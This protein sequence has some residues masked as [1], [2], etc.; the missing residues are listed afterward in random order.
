MA[1]GMT[2]G[3]LKDVPAFHPDVLERP[4]LP[5]Y[6]YDVNGDL[7]T[8][9]HDAQKRIPIKMSDV[10]EDLRNAFLAAEDNNFFNHAGFDAK[11]FL[12]AVYNNLVSAT[13]EGGS[14]LTQQIVKQVFVGTERKM[15]RKIKELY[16]A[17]DME[18]RYTKDEIFEF[19]IN[20]VT[21]YGNSAYGV[22]A[23][24][25]TY[26][27]KSVSELT[28]SESALLAGIPNWPS[29]YAPNSD[30]IG[31]DS[32]AVKRRNDV[33]ARMLRF[34]Y[35]TQEEFDQAKTEEVNLKLSINT[36]WPFPHFVDA[37]VH[38]HAIDALMSTGRYETRD[39]AAQA[40]R[41]DG[42]NIY[43]TLDPRIQTIVQDVMS[44]DKYYPKDT[45]EYPEGHSRAGRRYPQSAAVVMNPKTGYVYGMV[46]GREFNSVNRLNR[47]N[48]RFQPGSSIKPILDYG[49]AFELG[50]L[51]PASTIDDAPTVWPSVGAKDYTPENFGRNFKG[52]VTVRDALV[53]SDNIPAIKTYE[54]ILQNAGAKAGIEFAQKAGITN[55]GERNRNNPTAYAQLG[56]AI[57]S[58]EVT[59]LEMA[60]AYSAFANKGISTS[61]IFVTK[62]VDRDNL[63]I[64]SA[65]MGTQTVVFSEQ[66]AWQ[67]TD[68]LRDVVLRGTL[69]G[70]NLRNY[71]VAGKTGTT[72]DN[73]DRWRVGYTSDYVFSLWMGNDNKQATVD[74]KVVFIPGT[75]S[76]SGFSQAFGEIV[77]GTIG[78]NDVP[79]PSRPSGLVQVT[80]C[81][82]SGK[83][84]G[85]Y[86]TDTVTD[87]FT[88][89]TVPTETCDLHVRVPICTV[90]GLLATENCPD[91]LV[92]YKVFLNRPEVEPTDDRWSGAVGRLPRD[93]HLRPPTEYCTLHGVAYN[94]Q[95]S[96]GSLF[97]DWTQQDGSDFIGFNVY[98]TAFGKTEKLN[99][100][101]LNIFTRSFV[102]P[103]QVPGIPYEYR[104]VL[105][106]SQ[107][108]ETQRH[109]PIARTRTID[110]FILS[111]KADEDNPTS[112]KLD[113][114]APPLDVEVNLAGY[115]IY[116]NGTEIKTINQVSETKYTD[117]NLSPG[118]YNYKVTLLFSVD[119]QTYETTSGA[120]N[121][122]VISDDQGGTG[123][124]DDDGDDED[125]DDDDDD[126]GF[127]W[128]FPAYLLA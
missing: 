62:I 38:T 114:N 30:N 94:F 118:E 111:V 59:P 73:H 57:G 28:L 126:I 56:T 11:G 63:E 32:P 46:G 115:R 15:D 34:G 100:E 13:G 60:Q 112:A 117:P 77:R 89:A 116:R 82:K 21:F 5:S 110:G 124:D 78:D 36:G 91:H 65:T 76:G 24:A 48:L 49:P 101:V 97:W 33:L 125:D 16:L 26:F 70:A 8:E 37:V 99:S 107:G 29:Y 47:Y 71:Q 92:E 53:H 6:I 74:G 69:T 103:V 3:A 35:I 121:S 104:L 58:Q 93:Y 123:G 85:D 45:F 4:F 7:I 41:R 95:Y 42:L 20:N 52:L 98:R 31:S 50:L 44:D 22:E 40:I 88:N 14:T 102:V 1:A 51:A 27:S 120:T 75:S 64:F 25:Q 90:N 109:S 67:I 61:P 119:N 105:V 106:N 86:C 122:I 43:T 18:R 79:L 23:A 113:W 55:Y 81:S 9:I 72:N 108:R 80:V 19:Y 96:S 10:P 87:W 66:T 17:L 39:E 84:P 83:L 128:S 54:M 12:R 68:I 2:A 127:L